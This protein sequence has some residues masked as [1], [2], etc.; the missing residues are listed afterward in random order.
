MALSN[1]CLA[2]TKF[3]GTNLADLLTILNDAVPE[4]QQSSPGAI[5]QVLDCLDAKIHGL[6]WLYA[7][8][9]SLCSGSSLNAL[10]L[11][12]FSRKVRA[13]LPYC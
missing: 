7:L 8:H 3:S 12:C 4:L 5:L 11:N 2:V 6:G 9:A 1:F 10:D 13:G